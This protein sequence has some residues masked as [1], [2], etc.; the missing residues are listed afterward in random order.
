M[1]TKAEALQ[2]DEL[3]SHLVREVGMNV[4]AAVIRARETLARNTEGQRLLNQ[5]RIAQDTG[6]LPQCTHRR[7]LMDWSGEQLVPPCGCRLV[8]PSVEY[9][10]RRLVGLGRPERARKAPVRKPSA[11]KPSTKSSRRRG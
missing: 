4:V 8:E 10:D 9:I 5:L 11:R 2:I 3:L 1:M 6:V 7:P